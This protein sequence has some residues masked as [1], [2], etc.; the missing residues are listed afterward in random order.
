MRPPGLLQS[1]LLLLHLLLSRPKFTGRNSPSR[2]NSPPHVVKRDESMCSVS[3]YKTICSVFVRASFLLRPFR[4]S[5]VRPCLT[6]N[7]RVHFVVRH[8]SMTS[9]VKLSWQL[10]VSDIPEQVESLITKTRAVY[11]AVGSVAPEKGTY[12]T[13]IKVSAASDTGSA[14]AGGT[15]F[16]CHLAYQELNIFSLLTVWWEVW[17]A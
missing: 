5:L 10:E 1:V 9:G 12:S 3:S 14:G 11:D 6:P 2:K 15:K 16:R 13:V 8:S 7:L 4:Q 17:N